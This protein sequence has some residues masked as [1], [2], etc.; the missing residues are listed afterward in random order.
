[1]LRLPVVK[2][3]FKPGLRPTS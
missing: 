1:M 2:T 3:Q